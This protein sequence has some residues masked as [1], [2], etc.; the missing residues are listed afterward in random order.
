MLAF[1]AIVIFLKCNDV[2]NNVS[3]I[4]LL[5]LMTSVVES[6]LPFFCHVTSIPTWP[7]NM[8]VRLNV[9]PLFTMIFSMPFFI[10]GTD[11][12]YEHKK[13]VNGKLIITAHHKQSHSVKQ[14]NQIL[15]HL[16]EYHIVGINAYHDR[17][18]Q[19]I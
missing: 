12:V 9:V 4:E 19:S 15:S 3:L 6:G 10:I 18:L 11:P 17:S 16:L 7:V 14:T 8:H 1:S 13:T 5:I 2:M